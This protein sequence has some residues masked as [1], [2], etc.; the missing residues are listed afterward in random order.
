MSITEFIEKITQDPIYLTA[1]L[2]GIVAVI[3]T[4]ISYQARTQRRLI[5]V[6]SV[7]T[8]TFALHYVMIGSY[9][10]ALS[11]AVCVLRNFIYC[12]R[13]KK[14]FSGRYVPYLLALLIAALGALS[15]QGPASLL[16]IAALMIN[17]VIMS[18]DNAQLLR[19]SILLTSTMIL[20]YDI[21]V[22]SV[23]GIINESVALVS[24]VIGI[25]RYRR[26]NRYVTAPEKEEDS[27]E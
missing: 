2:I 23:G 20:I 25:I 22:M 19:K 8:S 21:I 1:Q 13:D 18:M 7:A 5:V 24:A 10:A 12:N 11:N 15:W 27:V 6:Q 17:T 26:G 9:V 4:F 14:A 3:F 16:M